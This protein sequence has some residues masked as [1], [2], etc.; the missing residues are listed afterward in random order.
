M[1]LLALLTTE[2]VAAQATPTAAPIVPD[3]CASQKRTNDDPD[4]AGAANMPNDRLRLDA[5]VGLTVGQ[6]PRSELVLV[7]PL[8]KA[9][10]RWS[11]RLA[12]GV[13]WGWLIADETAQSTESQSA[14]APGNPQLLGELTLIET[15]RD[16]LLVRAGATVPAAW[17]PSTVV[18]RGFIRG[19]YGYASATRGLWNAWLWGPEQLALSVGADWNRRLSPTVR[20]GAEADAAYSIPLVPRFRQLADLFLQLAPWAEVYGPHFAFGVRAQAVIMVAA[21][22][23]LQLSAAPY[24]RA[25]LGALS[26]Q[27]QV[28]LN[29]DAPLG[30]M[31]GG[32]GIWGLLVSMQ[33]RL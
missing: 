11:K 21:G 15:P 5:E 1:A 6:S 31:D 14:F 7:S 10:Y 18:R 3:G 13:A 24:V 22:D 12:F 9:R 26:L 23:H 27:A 20:G 2:R 19:A 25:E 32:L 4:Q 29:L 17:L 33:G 30:Y 16:Q 28:L 8:L